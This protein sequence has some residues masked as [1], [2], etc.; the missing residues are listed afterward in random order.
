MFKQTDNSP[1]GKKVRLILFGK[2]QN[3][4]TFCRISR[5]YFMSLQIFLYVGLALGLRQMHPVILAQ[6]DF[7][8]R[9][10]KFNFGHAMS[11]I[12][13]DISD[14]STVIRPILFRSTQLRLRKLK[15]RAGILALVD[16]RR[17]VHLVPFLRHQA[18]AC[19]GI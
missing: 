16:A 13:D 17:F 7:L 3:L 5:F 4:T 15:W 1:N 12:I 2:K 6:Y 10:S 14:L 18:L 11:R 8:H 19:T 9:E